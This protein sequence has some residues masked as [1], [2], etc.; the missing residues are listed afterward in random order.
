ME[1]TEKTTMTFREYWGELMK[2]YDTLTFSKIIYRYHK[3][4]VQHKKKLNANEFHCINVIVNLFICF[5][6]LMFS[7]DYTSRTIATL[8]QFLKY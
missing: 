4:M 6:L 1:Q 3:L 7:G 5:N 2:I 8:L